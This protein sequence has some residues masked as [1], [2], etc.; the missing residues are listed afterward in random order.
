MA[1]Y[2]KISTRIWNDDKFSLL[3]CDAKLLFFF[4]LSHPHMTPLGA[5]RANSPGIA[6]ELSWP[7]ERLSEALREVSTKGMVRVDERV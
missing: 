5:M 2:R 7:L 4:L 3:S 6:H 1:K